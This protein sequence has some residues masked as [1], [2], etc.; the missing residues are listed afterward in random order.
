MVALIYAVQEWKL[1][2]ITCSLD[3]E[4][5]AGQLFLKYGDF[6]ALP[7]TEEA[8]SAKVIQFARPTSG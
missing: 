2:V 1:P 7:M 6:K 3:E 4:N 5:L 8:R